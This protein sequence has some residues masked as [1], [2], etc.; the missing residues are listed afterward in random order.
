MDAALTLDRPR[1]RFWPLALT[2]AWFA[3][4]CAVLGWRLHELQVVSRDELVRRAA[5]QQVRTWSIP[6]QRG[7][8]VD[9]SGAPLVTSVGT[10]TLRA[11]PDYMDDK[12]RAT[13]ELSRILGV[14]RETLRRQFES[15]RNGRI[16]AKEIR[17]GEP[18]EHDLPGELQEL[19]KPSDRKKPRL[20][21]VSLV[22][23]F[24]RTYPEARLAP[25]LLGFVQAD[26]GGGLG[27]EQ[28]FNAA[29]TGTP[30]SEKLSVDALGK[31]VLDGAI[32]TPPRPG[33]N[34]Q[35]AID[36]SVQRLVQAELLAGV[37]KLRPQNAAAIVVRPATGEI[38]AMASWPDFDPVDRSGL[39]ASSMR[40]NCLTFVY[41]PGSTM[42][43][44]VAGAAVAE[45]L[46]RWDE[47][48]DCEHG[49]WKFQNSPPVREKTGGHGVLSLVEC[50]ALSDNIA[51]AKLGVRLGPARLADW[52]ERLG[53]GRPT[54]IELPGEDAGLV[55]AKARWKLGEHCLRI[56][57]GHGVAV[58]PLQL[59]MAHAAVANGGL[60]HPPRLV[61]R[62]WI[63]D[64]TAHGQDLDLPKQPD[65]HRVFSAAEALA[66]Q[67][68]MT[69]T[70]TEGTG[71]RVQLD[72]YSS[73][74]K[75]GTAEKI[76]DGRY[77]SNH[78]VGSFVCWAP[79]ESGARAELC[80]LVVIDDPSQNGRFGADTAAP[81]VREI[82]QGSLEYLKIPKR[83]EPEVRDGKR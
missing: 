73:A 58:T 47:L 36:L 18:G 64:G 14:P 83:P 20:A 10:W 39:V 78:N 7:A 32:S 49:H 57:M 76:I 66:I 17:D 72:G 81:I 16:L 26:G 46:A 41:E 51:M 77:A 19:I 54:G 29:M 6:A 12:L 21:G 25:H 24:T 40:N 67:S 8:I 68:A 28:A 43:P 9:V 61:R 59:V 34:I 27:I 31:P 62:M 48:I 4:L 70:M 55:A 80:C 45:G 56:P 75:T 33:A 1:P 5:A 37:E 65:S 63:D 79:A 2:F 71:K 42:K 74:G 11:D 38:L 3:G 50:I 35:L 22:R 15:G 13:V 60:W 23:E 82:L 52:I 69:H 44:L 53:F 30:G